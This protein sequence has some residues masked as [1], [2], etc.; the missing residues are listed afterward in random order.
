MSELKLATRDQQ[1]A[2]RPGETIQGAVGWS[3]SAAPSSLEVRLFWYTEGKGTQDVTLVDSV[4]WPSPEAQGAQPF[5]F[6]APAFPHSFSGKL[7]SL[8]WALEFVVDQ[9]KEAARL[10]LVISPTGRELELGPT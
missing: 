6:T 7:I 10:N 5:Q 4:Q 3:L 9:G 1:T 8:L 2:F